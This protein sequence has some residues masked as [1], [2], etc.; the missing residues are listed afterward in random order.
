MERN[1]QVV[2]LVDSMTHKFLGQA[3]FCA[4][5][6]ECPYFAINDRVMTGELFEAFS[7]GAKEM[8]GK[9]NLYHINMP[10]VIDSN[11]TPYNEIRNTIVKEMQIRTVKSE[12]GDTY[13]RS[14]SIE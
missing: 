10:I 12:K 6:T 5:R 8:E 7:L 3:L 14:S 9:V 13:E 1:F 11:N 4:E 2:D